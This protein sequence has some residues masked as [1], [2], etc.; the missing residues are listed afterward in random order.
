MGEDL[1]RSTRG[2]GAER[3]GFSDNHVRGLHASARGNAAAYGYSATITASFGIIGAVVG[4]PRVAEIFAFALGAVLAF[5]LVEAV[6]SGG[7]KHGLRDEPSDVKAPGGSISVF[8]MGFGLCG[9]LLAGLFAGGF[10]AW[11]VGASLT[12]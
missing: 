9:S 7:F 6:I 10:P 12:P 2:Q 1:D 4:T 3:R 11:P 8:S 5:A